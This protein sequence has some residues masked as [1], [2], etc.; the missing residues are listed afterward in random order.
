VFKLITSGTL[1]EKISAIIERKRRLMNSVVQ[2]DDPHLDKI[3][4]REELIDILKPV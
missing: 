3:F 1:E 2:V 4:T